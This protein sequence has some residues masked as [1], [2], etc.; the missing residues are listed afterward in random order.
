MQV[1]EKMENEIKYL[2]KLV[3][4]DADKNELV[5]YKKEI[6]KMQK[7]IKTVLDMFT[8]TTIEKEKMNAQIKYLTTNVVSSQAQTIQSL[9]T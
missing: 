1:Q 4:Q 6:E 3:T 7:E 2:T 5:N 8:K 9:N